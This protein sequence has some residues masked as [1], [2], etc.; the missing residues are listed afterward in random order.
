MAAVGLLAAPLA[1]EL[2]SRPDAGRF[3]ARLFA[4]DAYAGLV[5]GLLLFMV[6]MQRARLDAELG[7]GSRFSTDML[8][9]LAALFC[10]VA[11]H[12]GVQPLMQSARGGSPAP[13]FA[14]LHGLALAFFIVKFTATAAL[15]WRLTGRAATVAAPTS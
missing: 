6:T 4:A 10:V 12:F 11:G 15:A 13:S 14:V 8:L 2:L 7:R 5:L 3:V 9:A 1:F